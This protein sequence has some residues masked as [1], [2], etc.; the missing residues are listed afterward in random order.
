MYKFR[1]GVVVRHKNKN[2]WGH[3][4]GFALNPVNETVIT[5]RW[6]DGTE[7]M[8]HPANVEIENNN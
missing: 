3:V 1:L 6:A 4:T 5:V 2:L 7:N 8:T